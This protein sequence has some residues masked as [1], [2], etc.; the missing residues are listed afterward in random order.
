MAA[1]DNGELIVISVEKAGTL[2]LSCL[3]LLLLGAS[4]KPAAGQATGGTSPL[5]TG[6]I[7]ETVSCTQDPEQTYALYLPAAY[8]PAKAWPIL[9]AFDPDARGIA[10]VKRYKDVVEKYGF[11]LA[12][13]NNSRNFSAQESLRGTSAMWQDTHARFSIDPR[14]TYTTGF[15]GGARMAGTVAARCDSC[16]IAGV[17]AHGAGYPNG[18]R[19]EGERLPY[20]LSVGDQDF[21]WLEVIGIRREREELGLPYRVQVFAGSH[22]WAPEAVFE[23]AVEWMQLKAMQ[24]GSQ[25]RDEAFIDRDWQK[26]QSQA[27]NARKQGDAMAELNSLRSLVSDFSGLRDV[28]AYQAQLNELK[29]SATLKEALKKEQEQIA[30]QQSL[31]DEISPKISSL[32]KLQGEERMTMRS[33][34]LGAMTHLKDEGAHNKN[35]QKRLVFAR[36]FNGL[37]AQGVEAGQAEFE[38]KH[39]ATAQDYFQLMGELDDDPWPALLLAETHTAM[40]N[41]KQAIKDLREAV[42]RGVK[43]PEVFEKDRNLQ[44]LASEADFQK[45]VAEMKS[46]ATVR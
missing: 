11:I 46:K 12:A 44:A 37:W 13:S 8:T 28:T 9:Y 29:A 20:F 36:S 24:S 6:Q 21:N 39:M 1:Q 38:A 35:E 10:P 22:Q 33:E 17:I 40:G 7:I 2:L 41:R 30:T 3:V 43:R 31:M 4:V 23:E 45:L 16:K 32:G 5:P 27:E 26:T 42:K 15:S 14:R 34:I 19:V 18:A 25:Q